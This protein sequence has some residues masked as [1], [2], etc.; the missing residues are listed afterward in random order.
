MKIFAKYIFTNSFRKH[1]LFFVTLIVYCH[2]LSAQ[3]QRQIIDANTKEPIPFATIIPDNKFEYAVVS[4][5]DGFYELTLPKGID[6]VTIKHISYKTK[7]ISQAEFHSSSIIRMNSSVINIK[8]VRVKAK[9]NPVHRIIRKAAKNKRLHNPDNKNYICDIYNKTTGGTIFKEKA[10]MDSVTQKLKIFSDSSYYFIMETTATKY[11]R[12]NKGSKSIVKAV[13]VSGFKHP[14]LFIPN[15]NIQPF[16]FYDEYINLSGILYLNPISRQ[17]VGKYYYE[18]QDTIV[19]N[20]DTIF[21][22]FF[23]PL[24]GKVFNGLKGQMRI[25][26]NGYAIKDINTEPAG[27][28]LLKIK[29]NQEYDF[30]ND[31][32]FPT[33]INYDMLIQDITFKDMLIK[34]KGRSRMSNITMDT[35]YKKVKIND[36]P[37]LFDKNAFDKDTNYWNNYRIKALSEKEQNTYQFM[38]SVSEKI[39]SIE[40]MMNW[41]FTLIESGKIPIKF[42]SL[43]VQ[44]IYN[45]NSYEGRQLGFGLYTNQYL[46][47]WLELGGYFRY[48]FKD[49]R[50]KYG[51]DITFT[52]NKMRKFNIGGGYRNDLYEPAFNSFAEEYFNIF[53]SRLLLNHADSVVQYFAFAERQLGKWFVN[54]TAQQK[55]VKPLYS[56]IFNNNEYKFDNQE[57]K[58]FVRYAPNEKHNYLLGH[59]F[60]SHNS[61][62]FNLKYA[63]GF[64]NKEYADHYN[65]LTFTALHK[66]KITGIGESNVMLKTAY[67]DKP[68][69][70]FTLI[71]GGG[72]FDKNMPFVFKN[73]FQT[74][75]T[76]EFYNSLYGAIF[77][78]HNFG[79]IL[80]ISDEVKPELEISQNVGWG[81]LHKPELHTTKQLQDIHKGY[82][83]SGIILRNILRY[84][85]FN[86][87]YVGVGCGTFYRYGDYKFKK[88]ID[89]FAFKLA[90]SVRY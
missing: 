30:I 89:N 25:S 37:F 34:L 1:I 15:D 10:K 90:L 70:L 56:Y 39:V 55:Y 9:D 51:G 7:V 61:P 13:K 49:K 57:F 68:T 71:E 53:S 16:H 54:I 32:W 85:M 19:N 47:K 21:S 76:G 18:M 35:V 8:E 24:K 87:A 31:C 60:I 4:N 82:F 77:Y 69:P 50:F 17:A 74:M 65:K 2:N 83:E 12:K 86:V 62:V 3:I 20:Q 23:R 42:I 14:E 40:D 28:H 66:F 75:R 6:S 22:I 44:N 43:D 26:T 41:W 38:D 78:T 80:K 64:F 88:E 46:L 52:L 33:G 58:I 81:K 36:I 79:P 63:I 45:I 59:S 84:N 48:G 73:Y 67:I 29:I 5:I 72:S 27:H 11:Y